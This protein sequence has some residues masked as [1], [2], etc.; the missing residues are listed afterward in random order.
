VAYG[1]A[2]GGINIAQQLISGIKA[3]SSAAWRNGSM[4]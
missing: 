2:H 4:A 1:V 3:A